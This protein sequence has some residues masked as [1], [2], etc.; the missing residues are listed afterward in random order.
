[1]SHVPRNSPP[2]PPA[3]AAG[4]LLD[5]Y[6]ADR[7]LP[8]YVPGEPSGLAAALA[9]AETAPEFLESL[10]EVFGVDR[11]DEETF[12]RV[13]LMGALAQ[14]RTGT[15][16][17]STEDRLRV[18]GPSC[19]LRQAVRRDPRACQACRA[20]HEHVARLAL[21]ERVDAVT[22]DRLISE[23]ASVCDMSIHLRRQIP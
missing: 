11:W 20:F 2:V 23:G 5:A 17:A 3:S 8:P 12:L 7:A 21:R 9:A 1:M 15:V 16:V 14:W 22:F 19:P 6:L 18:L 4:A 10:A 13:Y